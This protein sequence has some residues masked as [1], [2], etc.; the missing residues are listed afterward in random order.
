MRFEGTLREWNDDRGFGFVQ[1]AQGGEAIFV[2]VKA[3]ARGVRRPQAG[4]RVTF[5]VET[6]PKGKRAKNVAP[7]R[8]PR[9]SAASPRQAAAQWGTATLFAIPAFLVLYLA[10]ALLWKPP[11]ALAVFYVVASVATFAA[12]AIDKGAA[13]AGSWRTPEATLHLFALAGGWP[14]ALLAQQF[15]R[16]KS[17][18]REFRS[19]FWATV[20]LNVAAFVALCSPW[21]R[22]LWAGLVR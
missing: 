6:G 17:A 19:L 2:H 4:D 21:G 18:K 14:G 16:H 3:F 9:N 7:L 22:P 20:V 12:Y 11:R 8:V 13:R 10:V 1:P 5:E 15:L